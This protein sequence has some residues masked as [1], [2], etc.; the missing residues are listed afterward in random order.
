NRTTLVGLVVV[1]SVCCGRSDRSASVRYDR[2]AVPSVPGQNPAPDDRADWIRPAK[3]FASTR[4]SS[5][6]QITAESVAGLGVRSTFSTGIARGHEAAPLV[7]N[8]TMY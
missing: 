3:G 7:V 6:T 8:G 5:L 1:T 4:F 2:A